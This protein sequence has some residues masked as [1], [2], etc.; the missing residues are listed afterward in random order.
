[1]SAKIELTAESFDLYTEIEILDANFEH[2]SLPENLG[3]VSVELNPGTYAVRFR[4]GD[5]VTVR[6]RHG[7]R[8]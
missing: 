1:M 7:C 5:A 3:R 2:V 6:L 8:Q 4:A